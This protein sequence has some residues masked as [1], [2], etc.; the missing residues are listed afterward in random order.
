MN[1]LSVKVIRKQKEAE[2]I[3]SLEL[4]RAD[5]GSLPSFSAGSHIDV[6]IKPD[7]IR[8]YSLCNHPEERHRYL[9]AVLRDPAS[10]GGSAAIHDEIQEGDLMEISEPKNHFMLMRARR[11][12]LFAGGIG[13][14]PI[15][16]MAERLAHTGDDFELHYCTR[17]S[18]RTAFRNRIAGSYFADQVYYHFDDGDDTQKL[19]LHELLDVPDNSTHMYICG[20]AGF[21][22]YVCQTA[23]DCGWRSGNVHYEYFSAPPADTSNDSTFDVEIA[24]TGEIISIPPGRTVTNVLKQ[25]GVDIGVACQRGVCGTCVT[26]VLE[27]IPEH[28]DHYLSTEEK[29][30]ND[31]FTPCCSRSK[32]SLLVLDL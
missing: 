11:S 12:L 16:C 21:L 27:G 30:K 23:Q 4:G 8:Q 5:G 10:R 1:M 31:Q 29:A 19:D 2:D 7:L 28:R 25:H 24:G 17:S 15:L 26:R 6:R 22:D 18:D 9:I 13:V 20:P 3:V 32:T 14:T